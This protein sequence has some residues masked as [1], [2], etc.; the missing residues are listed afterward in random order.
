[1]G[2]LELSHWIT[3]FFFFLLV[4]IDKAV[5]FPYS[6]DLLTGV[7][8]QYNPFSNVS[9]NLLVIVHVWF[10]VSIHW[11]VWKTPRVWKCFLISVTEFFLFQKLLSFKGGKGI[12]DLS[13]AFIHLSLNSIICL[14]FRSALAQRCSFSNHLYLASHDRWSAQNSKSWCNKYWLKN[15]EIVT[16]LQKRSRKQVRFVLGGCSLERWLMSRSV[17]LPLVKNCLWAS[18]MSPFH[19]VNCEDVTLSIIKTLR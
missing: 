1:M 2:L 15:S 9:E 19:M 16:Y 14:S 5:L 18:G 17:C 3:V 4:W 8:L 11:K 10:L 7:K 6:I 13:D 12:W